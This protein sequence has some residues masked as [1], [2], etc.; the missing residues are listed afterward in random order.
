MICQWKHQRAYATPGIELQR[1]LWCPDCKK[2]LSRAES[3]NVHLR[4]L[5]KL[6]N[7]PESEEQRKL[8]NEG[9]GNAKP[10]AA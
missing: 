2:R 4:M 7:I 9:G 5:R 1:K 8:E 3:T 10:D 6:C